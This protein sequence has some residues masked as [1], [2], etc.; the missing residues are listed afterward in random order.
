MVCTR[1]SLVNPTGTLV[2]AR[3]GEI[4]P[5]TLGL[6]ID[7]HPPEDGPRVSSTLQREVPLDRRGRGVRV[8]PGQ[9]VSGVR[10]RAQA[11]LRARSEQQLA[12][13][14]PG[15]RAGFGPAPDSAI[16]Q[17]TTDPLWLR[18]PD[19]EPEYVRPRRAPAVVAPRQLPAAPLGRRLAAS[20]VDAG[21]IGAVVVFAW[22]GAVVAFGPER[23]APHAERGFDW[24]LDGLVLGRGLGALTLA[25]GSL[26][27]FAYVTLSH[28]LAGRTFGKHLLRLHLA[29]RNGER[30]SLGDAAWRS[31]AVP[32]SVLP[33]GAGLL[34]AA[35]DD[36]GRTLHDRLVGTEVVRD[37][38]A[39]EAENQEPSAGPIAST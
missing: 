16:H 19:P 38:P 28:A 27:S 18:Q 12:L 21:L 35:F 31:L 22:V 1:C 36:R 34:L 9:Q 5:R 20:L 7:T 33:G 6:V 10:G 24:L 23:L 37:E 32:V 17:A 4:T 3:C 26:L 13:R 29:K 30:L 8:A 2:C 14:L 11:R 25:L 15:P 39:P